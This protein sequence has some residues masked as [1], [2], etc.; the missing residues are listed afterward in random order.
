MYFGLAFMAIMGGMFL[1]SFCGLMPLY[2][3]PIIPD[4]FR[5]ILFIVGVVVAVAGFMLL[6][7]RAKKTGAHHIINPSAPGSVLWFFVYRDGDIRITPSFRTGE[8]QLYNPELDSQIFDVKTYNLADHKVRI[9]PEIVGHAVDLDYVMYVDLLNSKYGFENIREVRQDI[10]T[11]LKEKI[12]FE[13][14]KVISTEQL[15]SNPKNKEV[16]S[17]V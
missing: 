1:S 7:I 6:V 16:T 4:Y 11:R 8:G 2:Y 13:Q 3:Q 15:V 12:G 17:N 10:L 14:G 5:F 9:V